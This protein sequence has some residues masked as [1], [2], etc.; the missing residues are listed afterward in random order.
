M[1]P[2][3]EPR[4]KEFGTP[5]SEWLAR[6]PAELPVDAVG[7]WQVVAPLKYDFGLSGDA[8][9]GAVRTA[10][11]GLLAAGA[12]PVQ[13][14][15]NPSRWVMCQDLSGSDDLAVDL[16]V[17]YWQALGRDPHVGDI[18]FTLNRTWPNSSFKPSPLR[19]PA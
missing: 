2:T 14:A 17:D 12:V 16:V 6:I 7:L 4:H 13:G 8:L 5:L 10:V 1:Q 19:G 15:K 11:Q 9:V 18:W 3:G